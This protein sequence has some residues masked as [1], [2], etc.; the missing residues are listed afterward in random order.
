MSEIFDWVSR[1]YDQVDVVELW[2]V[3]ST[4]DHFE[5]LFDEVF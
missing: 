5:D 3:E 1:L 2:I 4:A